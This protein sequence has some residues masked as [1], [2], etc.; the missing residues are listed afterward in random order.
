MAGSLLHRA[1]D[2]VPDAVVVVVGPVRDL[3][4][5][6]RQV[7][8]DPPGSGPAAAVAAGLPAVVE[9]LSTARTSMDRATVAVLAADLPG[10][11]PETVQRLV[12]ALGS[13]DLADGPGPAGVVLIDAAGRRQYLVGVFRL[14]PLLA[15]VRGGALDRAAGPGLARSAGRR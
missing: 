13:G 15:A 3:P 10:I 14:G 11:T 6:V 9:Q 12:A 5:A 7:T 1:L 2:A 4:D 8:E